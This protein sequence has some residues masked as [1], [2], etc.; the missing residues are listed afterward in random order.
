G[1]FMRYHEIAEIVRVAAPIYLKFGLRN[2]PNIYPGG[3]HLEQSAI[4]TARERVRRAA[5]GLEM[6]ARSAQ[7]FAASQAGA[8]GLGIPELPVTGEPPHQ[9]I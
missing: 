6:L 3:I 7:D 5:L 8:P 4:L 9:P 2:A 1:G